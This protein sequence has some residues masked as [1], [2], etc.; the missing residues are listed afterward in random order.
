[1]SV[2]I[3]SRQTR[4]HHVGITNG[5]DLRCRNTEFQ[6]VIEVIHLPVAF[7]RLYYLIDV[8][9]V[10]DAVEVLVDVIEHVDHLHRCAVVT[11]CGKAYNVTEVDGDLFKKLR[12]H[13]SSF[14]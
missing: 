2:S 9:I 13:F 7:V 8:M 14:L 11:Q 4:D 12:L 3:P 1:M 10:K 6:Q 5:L